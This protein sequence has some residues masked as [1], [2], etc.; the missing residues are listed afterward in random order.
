MHQYVYSFLCSDLEF[1]IHPQGQD[2][3]VPKLC[4]V[5]ELGIHYGYLLLRIS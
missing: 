5:F 1:P 2:Y 4:I 3:I